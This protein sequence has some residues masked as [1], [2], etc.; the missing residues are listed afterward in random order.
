MQR[1]KTN[2][3]PT[4]ILCSDL[5][6]REDTPICFISDYQ[7]EQWQCL[8]FISNLQRK[9]DCIVLHGGDLFH[10]WKPSPWLI[11]MATRHLPKKFYS[12]AGQHDLPNHVFSLVEKSGINTLAESNKIFL[13][14]GV[15]YG[16]EIDE[17]KSDQYFAIKDKRILV[18]HKL[19][20]QTIPFPGATGGNAKELLKK[21]PQYDLLLLGDNHQTFVEEYQGRILV[22]PG[23]M[24]RMTAAQADHKPCV[25]LWYAETNTVIPVYLPIEEG[26]VSRE[27]IQVKEERDMRIEAFVEKLKGDYK[28]ELNF[29]Q[30]LKLF[31]E[32]NDT[33]KDIQQI[34]YQMIEK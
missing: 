30:N 15:H 4:A 7:K 24:M 33:E 17:K 28:V 1:E 20:Y 31:F 32:S 18:W 3:N 27:H 5:H 10:H 26:V 2:I 12:I 19:A 21:Y 22:N 34:T 29:E 11:T 8:D 9:Y 23:S 6:L 25:F 14:D 16:Q 13:L